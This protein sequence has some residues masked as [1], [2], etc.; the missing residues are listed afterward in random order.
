MHKEFSAHSMAKM[1]MCIAIISVTAY[2][3]FPLPFTP[4]I[5]T[6]AT[7]AMGLTALVLTPKQ[8]FLTM[9][10][11]VILGGVV[12]LPILPG[13]LGGL[14][15][16]LGPTGGFY[17]AFIVAYT[18]ISIFKGPEINFKRYLLV[19]LGFSLTVVYVGGVASMM[20]VLDINLE[21]A[22]VQAVFP[23]IPGD[24]FKAFLAA[25]VGVKVNKALQS[26]S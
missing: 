26:L 12:G 9:T 10:A 25:F 8:T 5:I 4:C 21:T 15:R 7:A 22:L 16:L 18:L 2:I 20:Y 1:A 6:A 19:C 14:G 24:T 13:G 17:F 3:S 23:F 11:Y